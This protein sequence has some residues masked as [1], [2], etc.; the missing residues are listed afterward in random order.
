VVTGG[1][2]GQTR[3]SATAD[4]VTG[5][6]AVTV[7]SREPPPSR[8]GATAILR[9]LVTPWANVAIDGR[10]G[11]Q[12]VRGEEILKASTRAAALTRQLLAFSRQQILQ[13]KIFDL[14]AVVAEMEG[15]LERLLGVDVILDTRLDPGLGHVRADPG[16]IEQVIMNLVVNARDAMPAGGR[17]VIETANATLDEAYAR[18][19]PGVAPGAY[20]MVAASAA[21]KRRVRAA[22][23]RRG[24]ASEAISAMMRGSLIDTGLKNTDDEDLD[25]G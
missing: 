1:K 23:L 20:V 22:L 17:L 5:F 7:I 19:H 4:G 16:Q 3:V 6:T 2:I 8:P 24:F 10:N 11:G 14:N 21:R 25:I 18:I 12:R 13:P 9:M 15:M